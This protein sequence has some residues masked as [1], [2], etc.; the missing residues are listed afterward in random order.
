[1][2]AARLDPLRRTR[3]QFDHLGLVE[4][5]VATTDLHP[6]ALARQAATDEDGLAVD[7]RHA[8]AIVVEIGDIGLEFFHRKLKR[9]PGSVH[10]GGK[11][12]R[13][14][15]AGEDYLRFQLPAAS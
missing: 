1:M 13:R 6:Y 15:G 8:A 12:R 9:G 2:A 11:E 5:T 3:Q 10:P 14:I 4:I 7:A